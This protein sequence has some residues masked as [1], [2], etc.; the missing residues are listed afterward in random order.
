MSFHEI[1]PKLL[2]I[3]F[4]LTGSRIQ[5]FCSNTIKRLFELCI[6]NNPKNQCHQN[7]KHDLTQFYNSETLESGHAP[8]EISEP[9]VQ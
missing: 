6:L 2:L 7:A 4:T 5:N 1:L 3:L 8:Y 9:K